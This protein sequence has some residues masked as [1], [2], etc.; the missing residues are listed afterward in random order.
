[1]SY[2][3]CLITACYN[4]EEKRV[5]SFDEYLDSIRNQT[6]GYEN[7]EHILVNDGSTDNTKNILDKISKEYKNVYVYHLEK[8]NGSPGIPRN[9]GIEKAKSKYVM[10][11]DR[12]DCYREK[13]MEIMYNKIVEN[14]TDIVVSNYCIY[15]GK[16]YLKHETRKNS[17]YFVNK[18]CSNFYDA[19]ISDQSTIFNRNFLLKNNIKY[20]KT[21]AA[22][23]YYFHINALINTDKN[24][25]IL[26]N[27]YTRIFSSD[28]NNSLSHHFDKKQL[29]DSI[30]T[31][32]TLINQITMKDIHEDFLKAFYKETVLVS[33]GTYIRSYESKENKKMMFNYIHSYLSKFNNIKCELDIF[34]KIMYHLFIY[35]QFKLIELISCFI[36]YLFD[37]DW[38]KKLFRN[39]EYH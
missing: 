29:C 37:N 14:N 13:S 32:T 27:I 20:G 24:I 38:F 10:F 11:L 21:S 4:I 33:I 30:D 3:V 19:K 22:E 8:N 35:K 16:N 1:M 15:D 36:R 18:H 28:N 9:I 39:K 23:D 31:F 25:L 12:D 17:E 6:I 5:I 26:D 7:I 2:K 34:W